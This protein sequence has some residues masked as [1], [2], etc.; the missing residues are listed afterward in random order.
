MSDDDEHDDARKGRTTGNPAFPHPPWQYAWKSPQWHVLPL[1]TKL[2]AAPPLDHAA[3]R[4]ALARDVPVLAAEP[5]QPP[6]PPPE[7]AEAL[8]TDEH[9]LTVTLSGHP[10]H[11][12]VGTSL[13]L[14]VWKQ[15]QATTSS[16]PAAHTASSSVL[17]TPAAQVSLVASRALQW[18]SESTMEKETG[19]SPEKSQSSSNS[20]AGLVAITLARQPPADALAEWTNAL[21][22]LHWL[23][24][25][26]TTG[27]TPVQRMWLTH[28]QQ[29]QGQSSSDLLSTDEAGEL[30][31]YCLDTHSVVH[32]Y[33]MPDLWETSPADPAADNHAA[34]AS[35]LLGADLFQTVQSSILPLTQPRQ[36]VRLSLSSQ[37][38]LFSVTQ[39]GPTAATFGLR[40]LRPRTMLAV[41]NVLC[42]AGEGKRRGR[43]LPSEESAVGGFLTFLSL[44][45]LEEVRTL[46]LPFRPHRLYRWQWNGW[47]FLLCVASKEEGNQ[48]VAVRVDAATEISV[49]AG[50]APS[51]FAHRHPPQE[52]PTTAATN[53]PLF[54]SRFQVVPI[55]WSEEPEGRLELI[56]GSQGAQCAAVYHDRGQVRVIQ[57]TMESVDTM[58][59]DRA[60][61][62]AIYGRYRPPLTGETD[63]PVLLTRSQT[64]VATL[65][66]GSSTDSKVWCHTGHGWG[67]L[68]IGQQ[69]YWIGWQGQR[70][71]VAFCKPLATLPKQDDLLLV[72]SIRL[73]HEWHVPAVTT[74]ATL[75]TSSMVPMGP[76]S[77]TTGASSSA[78]DV[79]ALIVDAL[80]NITALNYRGTS[81]S[82]PT[83]PLRRFR[84]ALSQ[85]EKAQRLLKHCSSWTRL[86]L[87]SEATLHLNHVQ[88][89]VSLR[90]KSAQ[91]VLTMRQ[92]DMQHSEEVPF[93]LVLS[94]LAYHEDYFTAASLAL[95]LLQDGTSLR[96]LW[97]SYGKIRG[98]DDSDFAVLEGLLE[99]V[100]P[101]VKDAKK[102][103]GISPAVQ[104]ALTHLA[105]MTIGCLTKG[106][107]RMSSTLEQFLLRDKHYNTA[108]A[109]L[110]LVATAA[111]TLSDDPTSV[112]VAMG[113]GYITTKGVEHQALLWP[114]RALLNVGVARD[115]LGVILLLLNAT[116]PATLRNRKVSD[117]ASAVEPSLTMCKALVSLI[118]GASPDA[119]ELLLGLVD[120]E[121]RVL[122]WHSLSHETQL[123]L[124]LVRIRET[125]SPM[126]LQTSVRSW[127]LSQLQECLETEGSASSIN[128]Y[129]KMPRRWL[130]DLVLAVLLN[131]GCPL[132]EIQPNSLSSTQKS[133][134]SAPEFEKYCKTIESARE[135][136]RFSKGEFGVDSDLLIGAL[137][138]LE[139]RDVDWWEGAHLSTQDLLSSACYFAGRRSQREPLAPLNAPAV[140]RQCFLAGNVQAGAN[141]VGGFNG[142]VLEC[143]HVLVSNVG[144]EM[145]AAES[146]LLSEEVTTDGASS[147]EAVNGFAPQDAHFRILWLL[148]EHVLKIRQYGEFSTSVARGKTDPVA[149]ARV[150]LRTWW[151]IV[152]DSATTWLVHWLRQELE[153]VDNRSPHRLACA[154]LLRALIWPNNK[155]EGDS[156]PS[157]YLGAYL[158]LPSFFATQ[159][160]LS[161]CGLVEAVPEDLNFSVAAAPA[162]EP[163]SRPSMV[164]QTSDVSRL[165]S[166]TLSVDA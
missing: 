43:P 36:Q 13:H 118:V 148:R 134:D 106:G 57:Y 34:M 7:G 108:R 70:Q 95:D 94:W 137:L 3:A 12:H 128:V 114:V 92:A 16:D 126:L 11:P 68:G 19:N 24:L 154:A 113:K 64:V 22:V 10:L 9:V 74:N 100:S 38:S 112:A 54:I 102:K 18:P 71:N 88:P 90:G 93:D 20:S 103:G 30:F 51:L 152:P 121:A 87:T 161:A 25:D 138:V 162:T 97:E 41:S 80:E 127:A 48:A 99:G 101:I 50:K 46:Y 52:T 59:P 125:S 115:M 116:I 63:L 163:L 119:A 58:P 53:R 111:Y 55:V 133:D 153:I 156:D 159:L 49:P 67:I 96:H 157:A 79:E 143:C 39:D 37:D 136:L 27:L 66:T 32:V 117:L 72:Q 42:I 107:Y 1:P 142:L 33:R 28:L 82:P 155:L 135:V 147:L 65:T 77:G 123:E 6:P 76:S 73:F 35:F 166:S 104:G 45:T 78:V 124:A 109:A 140:M 23:S 56:V 160:A 15:V 85:R 122:Y 8:S 29:G 14:E 5:G 21:D 4:I 105:D 75:T 149:A 69:L 91:Y 26:R 151:R 83:S 60:D 164:R 146:F 2:P 17:E 98:E 120:E 40:H 158:R 89:V 62:A 130:R 110:M 139:R 141:L 47:I 81:P 150:C 129:E 61:L 144:L 165:S 131:A 84:K 132:E 145:D 86:S 31:L 44:R